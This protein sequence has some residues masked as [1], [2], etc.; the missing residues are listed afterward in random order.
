MWTCKIR[1]VD[2]KMLRV[3]KIPFFHV[4]GRLIQD[5]Q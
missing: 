4:D 1:V 3:H 5:R 2:K